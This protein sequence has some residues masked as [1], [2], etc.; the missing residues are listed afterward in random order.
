MCHR[1]DMCTSFGYT[2][3]NQAFCVYGF[4]GW[5]GGKREQRTSMAQRKVRKRECDKY[6]PKAECA[7]LTAWIRC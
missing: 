7:V 3:R 6:T 2:E 4:E 5:I 1:E